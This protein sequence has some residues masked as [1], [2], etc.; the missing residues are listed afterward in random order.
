[1]SSYS[2]LR[3]IFE[4]LSEHERRLAGT[5]FRGKV[6]EV[7]AEKKRVRIVIG[8]D[9]DGANVLT[10]WVPYAQTAGALKIHSAPSVGQVMAVR[11][12]TGDVEQGV[13]HPFHWTDDNASPSNSADEHILTLGGV[14]VKLVGDGLEISVG[15]T[16]VSITGGKVDIKTDHLAVNGASLTHNS[17][18]IGSTHKHTGVETGGGRSG[19]PA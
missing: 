18:E 10:P 13:A 8:K 2:I 11:A 17:K 1:M 14:T 9:S 19:P 6:Q 15:S 4:R 7:D 3:R 12:E 16:M 5:E